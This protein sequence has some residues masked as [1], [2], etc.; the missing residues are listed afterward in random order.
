LEG[1]NRFILRHASLVIA[2]DR[3][4]ADRL[5]ARGGLEDK[6]TI[7][8]PWPHETHLTAAGEPRLKDD[9]RIRFLFVGGGLLKPRIESFIHDRG[10]S[11]ALSLP[12]QPLEELGHSLSAAD[13]HVVSLGQEMAGIIHP[14][15]IYGAMAVGRPI[16]YLGPR[17][18][19]I[20]DLLE[21]HRIGWQVD[22]GDVDA[23]TATIAQAA[24]AD[25]PA[26]TEMGRRAAAALRQNLG[27]PLLCGQFCDR[28][29][30]IF[31]SRHPTET[32]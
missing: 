28:L 22:H 18:S 23:A 9:P 3:F 11:N 6:L 20:S 4:M 32:P 13:L 30:E 17:P 31:D 27:Q 21:T 26:L 8:P 1:V 2:L 24:S 10:L 19:H 29:E 15:K 7:I 25:S 5:R 16:L 14:C 12:Y